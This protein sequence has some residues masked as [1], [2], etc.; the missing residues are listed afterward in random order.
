MKNVS[1]LLITLL[2]VPGTSCKEKG[3]EAINYGK[4]QCH[5]CKMIISNPKFGAELITD[6]GRVI[7][8]DAIECMVNDLQDGN[9]KYRK[10][11]A[12]P[13]NEP[14]QLKRVSALQF[15]ITPEIRSPM[16]ANLSAYSTTNQ[17]AKKYQKQ[18]LSW[19]EMLEE[20]K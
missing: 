7:K 6:K 1:L 9:V 2:I 20:L 17:L 14:K 12:V 13:F 18:L 10:L 16:G 3:S 15:L 19:E 11:Y 5:F 4:D 8:Y